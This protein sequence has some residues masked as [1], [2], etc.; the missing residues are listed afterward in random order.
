M[1]RLLRKLKEKF[2]EFMTSTEMGYYESNLYASYDKPAARERQ[3]CEAL[4]AAREQAEQASERAGYAGAVGIGSDDIDFRIERVDKFKKH[5]LDCDNCGGPL[6]MGNNN[7]ASCN[8]CNSQYYLE[9]FKRDYSDDW[10]Y[11]RDY[12]PGPYWVDGGVSLRV[13]DTEKHIW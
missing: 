2:I 12:D 8:F 5:K 4:Q 9:G 1:K 6:T 11:E 7:I 10:E 3:L 13:V